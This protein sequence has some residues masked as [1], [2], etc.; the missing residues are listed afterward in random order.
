MLCISVCC[1]ESVRS[2]ASHVYVCLWPT[3]EK[4]GDGHGKHKEKVREMKQTG[5]VGQ[6]RERG[7]PAW[8][9]SV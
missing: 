1:L 9:P 4:D 7:A 5:K 8:P 3:K 2:H 6:G